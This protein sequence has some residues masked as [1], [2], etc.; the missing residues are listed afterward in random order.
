MV[1]LLPAG[2]HDGHAAL[3]GGRSSGHAARP[4]EVALYG[5]ADGA[6]SPA[7]SATAYVRVG[8]GSI[9]APPSEAYLCACL[10]AARQHFPGHAATVDVRD[11]TGALL[12]RWSHPGYRHLSLAAFL[13]E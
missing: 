8:G 11:G 5:G 3:E 1:V 13:L 9:G 2:R 6:T 12:T 7:F 10:R 4:I